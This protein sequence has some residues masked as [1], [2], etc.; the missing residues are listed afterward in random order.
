MSCEEN[1]ECLVKNKRERGKSPVVSEET[2]E[3]VLIRRTWGSS[4]WWR[5]GKRQGELLS[6]RSKS[7]WQPA[8]GGDC[9]GSSGLSILFHLKQPGYL[10]VS[11]KQTSWL[12]HILG[13]HRHW[14]IWITP[15]ARL[16]VSGLEECYM[17]MTL[18]FVS[19]TSGLNC[20]TEVVP[21]SERWRPGSI[22]WFRSPYQEIMVK[23][24]PPKSA[25][26]NIN[27]F[28]ENQKCSLWPKMQN[29]P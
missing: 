20:S 22:N 10:V 15:P 18:H 29:K 4:T 11:R 27:F 6:S 26:Q 5:W 12:R 2:R 19:A 14:K 16:Q 23:A 3:K 17:Q 7:T 21:E 8:A 25:W 9:G 1:R 28:G 24:G 13:Y